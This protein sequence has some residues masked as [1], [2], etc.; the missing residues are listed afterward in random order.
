MPYFPPHLRPLDQD[1]RP[2]T[3]ENQEPPS[4]S[5]EQTQVPSIEAEEQ[6]QTSPRQSEEPSQ[7][8]SIM[9]AEE[10]GQGPYLQLQSSSP[11][12][13]PPPTLPSTLTLTPLIGNS[14]AS[15]PQQSWANVFEEE[16]AEV[17]EIREAAW[18]VTDPNFEG[19]GPAPPVRPVREAVLCWYCG[20]THVRYYAMSQ[21][22]PGYEPDSRCFYR[23]W[24]VQEM[25]AELEV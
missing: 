17:L 16:R 4:Q 23:L 25:E 15:P 13:P 18:R 12:P 22:D 21:M 20:E 11:S 24:L 9:E 10:Q 3:E 14:H 6:S 8:P 2:Q 7:I 19:S 5:E 1:D